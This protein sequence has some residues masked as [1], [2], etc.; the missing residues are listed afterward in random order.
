M[1]TM[2]SVI[3]PAWN[4][5]HLLPRCL[6]SLLAQSHRPL[7]IIVIDDGSTDGTATVMRDYHE[8]HPEVHLISQPHRNVGPARNAGLSVARGEYIGFV[9]ADDW[10]EPDFY[11]ELV[12]IAETSGADVVVCGLWFHLGRI[13]APF[14]FLPRA[15]ALSGDRAA[16]LA[17]NP[18]RM[19]SFAWDKLYRRALLCDEAPFPAIYYED[20]ATTHESW[21]APTPSP[22]PA[23]RTTTTAC[24]RRALPE[25]SGRETP[26]PPSRP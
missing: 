23:A 14:P 17:L 8:R 19:P 18:I 7:E 12:R 10:V 22:S 3:V 11:A 24:A 20:I 1:T 9:D 4:V 2:V 21:L 25:T 15:S 26:S 6:D 16:G 13:K 5:A